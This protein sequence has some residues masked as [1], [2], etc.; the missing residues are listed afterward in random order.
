MEVILLKNISTLG[1]KHD[2]ISVKNGFG[3][4]FLI[5][6]GLAVIA[7]KSNMTKLDELVAKE[8]AAEDQRIEE[9]QA[10]AEKMQG[11]TLK[12]GVKSGTSGKI[13]GSITNIQIAKALNEQLELEIPRKKI[14]V[15]EEI[16]M[17]GE[18]KAT[19]NLH[20]QVPVEIGFELVK[21]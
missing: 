7:N 13:F 14:V 6:K 5:P 16:K 20:E 1:D 17:I 2:V 4:N 18:Y 21:E 3:R 15:D 19:I 9:Y 8:K 11:K 12:I 10:M